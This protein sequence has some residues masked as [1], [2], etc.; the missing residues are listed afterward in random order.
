MHKVRLSSRLATAFCGWGQ[1]RCGDGALSVTA[2]GMASRATIVI[3]CR[4]CGQVPVTA[5]EAAGPG[6]RAGVRYGTRARNRCQ[7]VQYPQRPAIASMR[8]P[9]LK[10]SS[11]PYAP[12]ESSTWSPVLRPRT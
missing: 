3:G 9:V 6:P 5:A 1:R 11:R 10:K 2:S 4:Q 7:C 8:A 12:S